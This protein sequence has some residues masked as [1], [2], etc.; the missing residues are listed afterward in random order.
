[1]A[2]IQTKVVLEV[3][4]TALK[5]DIN[6]SLNGVGSTINSQS[7]KQGAQYSNGFNEGVKGLAGKLAG[8]IAGVGFFELGKQAILLNDNIR[9]AEQNYTRMLGSA[10]EAQKR[11]E[12]IVEQARLTPLRQEELIRADQFLQGFGIRTEGTFLGIINAAS[13]TG[14]S[15]SEL[16][17][18][19]GQTSQSK[20]LENIYQL[21][22]R[23]IVTFNELK[24]AGIEFASDGSIVNSVEE[25]YSKIDQIIQDK[26]KGAAEEAS[27]TLTGQVST[28]IDTVNIALGEFS[29]QS[30]AYD[31]LTN[32]IGQFNRLSEDSP[33]IAGGIIGI[34]IAVGLLTTS[35]LVLGGPAT[36]IIAGLG[37]VIAG[38]AKAWNDNTGGMRDNA[39]KLGTQIDEIFGNIGLNL[40]DFMELS[41]GVGAAF[42][43][44][45]AIIGN[46]LINILSMVVGNIGNIIQVFSGLIK[47]FKGDFKGGMRD[48]FGGIAGIIVA[49]FDFAAKTVVDILNSLIDGFNKLNPGQKMQN[50]QRPNFSGDVKRFSQS[51]EMGGFPIG[52]NAIVKTNESGQEYIANARAT[53]ALATFF[54]EIAG[55]F[56]GNSSSIQDSYNQSYEQN[57]FGGQSNSGFPVPYGIT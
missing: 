26:F 23:G 36:L 33:I 49:P 8:V 37:L 28:A 40:N 39:E 19:L 45:A 3:D 12:D 13:A 47:F 9:R 38:V 57:N 44:V 11:V 43:T 51:F 14:T 7:K 18:I 35:L 42:G 20:S 56:G 21:A 2:D 5:R 1:M 50:I 30:G 55:D 15:V 22:E 4:D 48:V 32:I 46:T 31:L 16:G 29:E 41:N 27:K 10:E 24:E 52:K 6:K 53:N 54:D 17:K 25:T 34:A